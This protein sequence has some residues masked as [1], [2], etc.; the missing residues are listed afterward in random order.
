LDEESIARALES[1]DRNA[2]SQAKLI[3]DLLDVSRIIT[4]KMRVD[5]APVEL[6]QVIEAAL[7]TIGP[8]A[9]AKEISVESE[10]DPAAGPVAGDGA[11]LQ[12][13][14]WNLLSNAV[15]FTPKGGRI[16]V[17]LQRVNSSAEIT[18]TTRD[19]E[20]ARSSCLISLTISVKPIIRF[21]GRT[22]GSVWVWQ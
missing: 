16:Q 2:Q 8:A 10:F 6:A 12:Q 14:I 15:K 21:H 13:V 1:I 3:E 4:G 22:A 19:K 7:D 5:V 17:T 9:R 18:V 11:R 20:S